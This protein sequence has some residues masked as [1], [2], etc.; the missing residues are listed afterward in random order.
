M[1]NVK[2]R[3][4]IRHTRVRRRIVGTKARPRLSVYRSNKALFVQIIDD[5]QGITL[6]GRRM[7]RSA[8][9]AVEDAKEFGKMFAQEAKKVKIKA[10]VFDRGGYAY[11][12]RVAAFA[13]GAR[14]GG[15]EF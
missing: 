7:Q 5:E 4:M 12:G 11:H 1:K 15:L 8:T 14:E 3:R 9:K 6:L 10:V 13:Q 2:S